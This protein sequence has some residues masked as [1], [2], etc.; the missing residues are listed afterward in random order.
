V[1]AAISKT[2]YFKSNSRLEASGSQFLTLK[3]NIMPKTPTKEQSS[4]PMKLENIMSDD[5]PSL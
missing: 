3:S 5:H 1:E 4:S 2:R